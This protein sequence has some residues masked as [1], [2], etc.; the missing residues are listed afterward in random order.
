MIE[1]TLSSPDG[2]ASDVL[3]GES[4]EIARAEEMAWARIAWELIYNSGTTLKGSYPL[5]PG[6]GPL[7]LI[8]LD[9]PSFTPP[10]YTIIEPRDFRGV[11]KIAVSIKSARIRHGY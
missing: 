9:S 2:N 11:L 6:L 5:K 4:P 8:Y 10:C 3:R 1:S 7:T